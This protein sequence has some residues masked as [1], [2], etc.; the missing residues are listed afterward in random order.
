MIRKIDLDSIN[1]I[2]AD[3]II[4]SAS[5]VVKELIDNAIDAGATRILVKLKD[6]GLEEIEL[7]DNGKGIS[8]EDLIK[9]GKRGMTSKL[10]E[11][12]FQLESATHLGFRVR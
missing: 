7:L 4:K 11:K 8:K 6:E 3:Q 12:D 2:H 5:T 1:R 9:L 10:K